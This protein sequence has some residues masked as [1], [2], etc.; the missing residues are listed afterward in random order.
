MKDKRLEIRLTSELYNTLLIK[1]KASNITISNY[2]RNTITNSDLKVDN[3][4][5]IGK[6][7]GSVNSVGN[8]LNQIAH[9][10]NKA[11]N[12]NKLDDVNYDSILNK[13]IIIEQQLNEM[14]KEA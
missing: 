6:L 3:S 2:I 1:S 4:K 7:I 13:L 14:I 9:N 11:N 10:L 12:S 8:N 5:N